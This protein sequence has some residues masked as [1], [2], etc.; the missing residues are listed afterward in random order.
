VATDGIR[1]WE[2]T[3]REREREREWGGGN[4]WQRDE[5]CKN[6][7]LDDECMTQE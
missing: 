7:R 1:S 2:K 5:E 3:A 4:E 6:A